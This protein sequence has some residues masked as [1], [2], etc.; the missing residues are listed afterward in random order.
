MARAGGALGASSTTPAA[1][2]TRPVGRGSRRLMEEWAK[3]LLRACLLILLAVLLLSWVID[4][5]RCLLPWLIGIGLVAG[6]GWLAWWW[7]KRRRDRW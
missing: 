1:G 6:I 5:L 4:L 7:I 2:G 3:K